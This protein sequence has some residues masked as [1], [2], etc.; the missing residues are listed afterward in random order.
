V[1]QDVEERLRKQIKE[2]QTENT[3]LRLALRL[4]QKRHDE[5][6]QA[7]LEPWPMPEQTVDPIPPDSWGG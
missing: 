1:K 3:S 2:L 7:A 4:L 5:M 6:R